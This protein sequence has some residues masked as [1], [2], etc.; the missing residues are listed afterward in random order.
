MPWDSLAK[1]LREK[2][3]MLAG[4]L[5]RKVTPTS[6]TVWLPLQLLLPDPAQQRQRR[7]EVRHRRA[8][9]EHLYGGG[10]ECQ[11]TGVTIL[12]AAT[13]REYHADSRETHTV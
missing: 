4:P 8:C 13:A 12:A 5:L 3:H 11:S 7:P 10:R 6:V 9:H 1:T 2:P